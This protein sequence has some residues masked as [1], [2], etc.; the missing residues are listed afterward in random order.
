MTG[1][2]SLNIASFCST[3]FKNHCYDTICNCR[4]VL[5]MHTCMRVCTYVCMQKRW[6]Y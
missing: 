4:H 3:I 2:R 1:E 5:S 6:K